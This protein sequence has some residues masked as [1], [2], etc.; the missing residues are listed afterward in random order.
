MEMPL[1]FA[2][3]S[4]QLVERGAF[5]RG[6]L[7][8]GWKR[9]RHFDHV[10]RQEIRTFSSRELRGQ[11]HHVAGGDLWREDDDDRADHAL[12]LTD[13]LFRSALDE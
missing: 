5:F 6:H 3:V 10:E 2:I 12:E 4:A 7:R 8:V 9:V 13:R 1:L 11:R